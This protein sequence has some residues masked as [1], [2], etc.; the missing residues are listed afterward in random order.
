MVKTASNKMRMSKLEE[1]KA[2][3]GYVFLIPWLIIF[4]VF[5]AYPLVYGIFVS[6]TNYS[7]GNMEWV[8]G[9]NYAKIVNDYAFWRS[10]VAMLF[11]MI[12]TI[13][14]QVFIPMWMANVLRPHGKKFTIATKLLA[15]LPGVTCAVALVLSW[16]FMLDPNVGLLSTL[17]DAIGVSHFSVFDNAKISIPIMSVLIACTNI[18]ANLIIFCAALDAIP[19]D[20]F[21][22]AELDGAS[23]RQQFRKITIPLL[24]PTIVYV[25]ITT[26]IGA[27]QIFVIPQLLTGGGPNY[28]TST[29]LL[30]VYNTAF[31]NNQF[32]YASAI[33]VILFMITAIIAV[34]Q[35]RVTKQDNVE[36]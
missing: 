36:Y 32:G 28:S 21:E 23:R 18:G 12:I 30:M 17:L 3:W 14:L 8:G 20:Y 25:F 24:N 35:F 27:M 5:Y 9:H 11:Y 29:L 22:A 7:L 6:F 4:G 16:K 33:G 15:Y 31:S 1:Q 26:T 2:K 34:V 13:P 10:L 19:E